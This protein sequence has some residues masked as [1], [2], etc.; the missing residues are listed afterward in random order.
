MVS[1]EGMAG[2]ADGCLMSESELLRGASADSQAHSGCWP[3]DG[4]PLHGGMVSVVQYAAGLCTL[5][6]SSLVKKLT[7]QVFSVA[8]LCCF[9]LFCHCSLVW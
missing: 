1:D 2:D 5:P 7:F 6:H 8:F 9:D 4:S 3:V